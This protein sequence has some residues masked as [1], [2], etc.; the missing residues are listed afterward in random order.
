MTSIQTL[1][2]IMMER[3]GY[4]LKFEILMSIVVRDPNRLSILKAYERR[5]KEENDDRIY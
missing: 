1:E 2:E 3:N 4:K 5:L